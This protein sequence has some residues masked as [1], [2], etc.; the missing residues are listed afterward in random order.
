M[1][2]KLALKLSKHVLQVQDLPGARAFYRDMLGMQVIAEHE[3]SCL[4]SFDSGSE[5]AASLLLQHRSD[6]I[7]PTLEKRNVY[8]KIGLTVP[9]VD[10]AR[11]DLLEQGVQVSEPAQFLDVGY[12]CHFADPEGNEIELLQHRFEQNHQPANTVNHKTFGQVTL[13]V[14]DPEKSL[15]FYQDVL[16]MHLLSRQVITPYQ[17]TL[18]FLVCADE[19]TP[20]ADI[21]AVENR[22]WL[23]Q[24]PY[25]QLELQH[26][27]DA[28]ENNE[29]YFVPESIHAGFQGIEFAIDN[30]QT[31]YAVLKNH[32]PQAE[33]DVG[34]QQITLLDPDGVRIYLR[35]KSSTTA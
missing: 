20:I 25:A 11:A 35:E 7:S 34:S 8:W 18:Y 3:K 10:L 29:G 32:K 17:F 21:D 1:Q 30:L 12:L 5:D 23:W 22:E 6:L 15:R 4:L 13:R 24:R 27:W 19:S 2:Q 9:D 16:G 14:R 31:S 26:R 33:L 28:S